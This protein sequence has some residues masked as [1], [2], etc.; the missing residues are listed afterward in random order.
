MSDDFT[1]EELANLCRVHVATVR[2]WIAHGRLGA[3]R[4][5]GG[6]YRIPATEVKR[7]RQPVGAGQG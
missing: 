6:L 3:I 2:R 7:L 1:T 5:P 4:L